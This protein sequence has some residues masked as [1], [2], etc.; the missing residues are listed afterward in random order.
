MSNAVIVSVYRSQ[1][2]EGMYLIVPKAK[3]LKEVPQPLL[4]RFGPA[5]AAMAFLLTPEKKLARFES[6]QVLDSIADR[7]YFLQLPPPRDDEMVDIAMKNSK[8]QR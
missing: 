4:D 5:T 3:G 7:G 8:I 6:S 1:K 2:E